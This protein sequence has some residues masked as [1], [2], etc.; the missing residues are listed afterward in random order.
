MA[1]NNNSNN[2]MYVWVCVCVHMIHI[3][4]CSIEN[5]WIFCSSTVSS[6]HSTHNTRVGAQY[7]KWWFALENNDIMNHMAMISVKGKPLFRSI[8]HRIVEL[9]G[10]SLRPICMPLQNIYYWHS[11]TIKKILHICWK[12]KIS[13]KIHAEIPVVAQTYRMGIP[14]YASC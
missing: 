7:R 1:Y 10:F 8:E 2:N 14:V 9:K 6:L 11:H 4:R 5:T 12:R 13:G 3:L